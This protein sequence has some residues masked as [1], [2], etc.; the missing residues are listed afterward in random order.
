MDESFGIKDKGRYI[1]QI[2]FKATDSDLEF[3]FTF[4]EVSLQE[5]ESLSEHFKIPLL[6]T[7]QGASEQ[8]DDLFHTLKLEKSQEPS[9]KKYIL[10]QYY[11]A[12][13]ANVVEKK[14]KMIEETRT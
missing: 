13:C 8:I 7:T 4:Y 12:K 9:L 3:R 11:S 14:M 6:M 1:K 10:L 2:K 5:G